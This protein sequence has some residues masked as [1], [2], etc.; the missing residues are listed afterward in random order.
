MNWG[1]RLHLSGCSS[2]SS[3]STFIRHARTPRPALSHR[4]TRPRTQTRCRRWTTPGPRAARCR[5]RFRFTRVRSRRSVGRSGR[6]ITPT[7]PCL[8]GHAHAHAHARHSSPSARHVESHAVAQQLGCCQIVGLGPGHWLDPRFGGRGGCHSPRA[9]S[10]AAPATAAGV[11]ESKRSLARPLPV[12]A[13]PL[14]PTR[15]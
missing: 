4:Q 15:G 1:K 2:Q 14:S 7:P 3:R 5:R 11:M 6:R 8:P 10:C 9:G 12:D 13:P